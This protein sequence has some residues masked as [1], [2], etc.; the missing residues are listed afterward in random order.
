MHS[1]LV[2]SGQ[3]K[4]TVLP[5]ELDH[6]LANL[7]TSPL[8]QVEKYLILLINKEWVITLG[9]SP[10][11]VFDYVTDPANI[12]DWMPFVYDSWADHT[13]SEEGPGVIRT[14]QAW[15]S[16]LTLEGSQ[17][18]P[19][20]SPYRNQIPQ[21]SHALLLLHEANTGSFQPPWCFDMFAWAS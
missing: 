4:A 18:W 16:S 12:K 21:I 11:E 1:Y 8:Q 2:G 3:N 15:D 5:D 6:D 17:E 13:K 19:T 9:A 7:T 20:G 14:I 10:Q